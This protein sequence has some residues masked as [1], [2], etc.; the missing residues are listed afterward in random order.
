M[1]NSQATLMRYRL[2]KLLPPTMNLLEQAT[3]GSELGP[4]IS[5]KGYGYLVT[6]NR[7]AAFN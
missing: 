5:L 3:S 1:R 6:L 2:V 4:K 7:N